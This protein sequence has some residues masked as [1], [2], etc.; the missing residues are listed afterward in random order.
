MLLLILFGAARL[1]RKYQIKLKIILM[2]WIEN[3]YVA[4]CV[5][6]VVAVRV[7]ILSCGDHLIQ[8]ICS[9]EN[10]KLPSNVES[11][12]FFAMY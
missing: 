9:I 5:C 6:I 1:A 7:Y 4:V 11:N 2:H 10:I 8:K 3:V 12:T